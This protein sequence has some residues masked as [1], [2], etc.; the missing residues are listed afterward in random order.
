VTL[1]Y[2]SLASFRHFYTHEV[3]S[4]PEEHQ[5]DKMTLL[6]SALGATWLR[7]GWDAVISTAMEDAAKERLAMDGA[8]PEEGPFVLIHPAA[9]WPLRRWPP[10][11]FAEAIDLLS[12]KGIRS[13]VNAGPGEEP[14]LDAIRE[15]CRSKPIYLWPPV[16]LDTLMG[17]LRISAAYLGNDSGPMHMAA[18]GVPAISIFGPSSP[19]RAAPRGSP[20]FP[21]YSALECS[22]C[23]PYYTRD[24]C[25]RG[26]N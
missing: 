13:I 16:P 19:Q 25:H 23:Q 22:P 5:A 1:G 3:D 20:F 11:K 17:I 12:E 8:K 24:T 21:F 14:L 18:A 15:K 26:H 9:K 2:F 6:T 7:D 4:D 10:E